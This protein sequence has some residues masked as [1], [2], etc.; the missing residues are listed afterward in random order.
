MIGIL[1]EKPSAMKNFASALGGKTGT[2]NGE[3]YI[4]TCSH[5]HLFGYKDPSLQV[6]ED[7]KE[8]YKSWNISLLPWNEKD[9][10]WTREKKPDAGPTIK[11]IKDALSS[12]DEICIATDVD[13]SGEGYLLATEILEETNCIKTKTKLTRMYFMDESPKEIQKAFVSRKTIKSLREHDEYK[14]A[15][16]RTKWDMLSMQF[17]RIATRYGNGKAVLRQGRLKSAMVKITGDGLKAV[18]E[19]KPVPYFQ[20]KFKDDHGVIYTSKNEPQYNK[21]SEVPGKYESSDVVFD[22]RERKSTPPP[23]LPDLASLSAMLAAKGHKAKDVLEVYQKMYDDNVVSYPRTED[24]EITPEQFNELLRNLNKIAAAVGADIGKLTH[25]SQRKTHVATGGA[26]GANRPGTNIPSSLKDVETKYGKLGAEIYKI[27][28]LSTLAMFAEDYEYDV[29]TGHIA[30]YPDFIGTSSV[31]Q[32]RGWKDIYNDESNKKDDAEEESEEGIGKKAEP[33]VYE[34]TVGKK[35]PK[36]TTKWLMKQLEKHD[37]GTGATRTSIYA[38]VTSETSKYPLLK[39]TKG[40]LSMTEYGTMSYNLLPDTHIGDLKITESLMSDMK[41]IGK[42]KK[43]SDSCLHEM[44]RFVKDDIE[45]MKKNSSKNSTLSDKYNGTWNG[46]AVSFNRTFRGKELT[47][48]QCRDLCEGK[49]I[50]ITGLTSKS[51]STY[52]I[53]GKLGY[54]EYEGNKYIGVEQIRFLNKSELG[55][56]A[57]NAARGVAFCKCPKCG[58]NILDLPSA[59]SCEDKSCGCVIF[60]Q[61]RFFEKLGKKMSPAAA[62]GLFERGAVKLK[63]IMSA[64]GNTYDAIIKVSFPEKYPSYQME[65]PPKKS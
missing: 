18:A 8:D 56:S 42:G 40:V 4:L 48:D 13:P 52:G 16:H 1:C 23:K 27:L 5:G 26:H 45:A 49:E 3:Q 25:I 31:P 47:D 65:F 35:P 59:Y 55:E 41:E 15:D 12:C 38:D 34:G 50:S 46:I 10:S 61:D 30:K 28:A 32:V 37:V 64:K 57:E 54:L 44:Q 58:K 17:T 7:K 6:P 51:G 39:E 29:E 36:P 20:N 53:M 22:G 24:K 63:N 60:K 19:Y 2:Y 43:D 62:K 21:K 9:F 33:F 11:S 14:M